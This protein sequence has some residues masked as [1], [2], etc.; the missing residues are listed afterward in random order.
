MRLHSIYN[1]CD[2]DAV[3]KSQHFTN[4]G[5]NMAEKKITSQNNAA[6][7]QNAN[8]GMPGQNKQYAQNQGNRGKQL[9]PNQAQKK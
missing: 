9:N 8:K 2:I 3:L 4:K 5:K 7:M 1:L 6:N